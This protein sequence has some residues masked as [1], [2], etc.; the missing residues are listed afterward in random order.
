V[1][2]S[3]EIG[4]RIAEAQREALAP[5]CDCTAELKRAEA[6]VRE[7]ERREATAR[8][9]LT[10]MPDPA[11]A[12]EPSTAAPVPKPSDDA[13]R[14][15]DRL[16]FGFAR[17]SVL[18]WA[19]DERHIG[20]VSTRLAEALLSKTSPAPK[21]GTG[22]VVR[23]AVAHVPIAGLIARDAADWRACGLAATGP[24]VIDTLSEA[25][26][27]PAVKAILLD[28]NSPGGVAT[29][30]SDIAGAVAAA[31]KRKLV[32]AHIDE[33]GASAGYWIASQAREVSATRSTLV[34]SIGIYRV[35][36]DFARAF[37]AAG[38]T[39]HVVR[40]HELKG[41]GVEGAPITAPQLATEQA[42]IDRAFGM[43]KAD[44]A[45]ARGRDLSEHATGQLWFAEDA[46]ARGLI[47]HISSS[48][49]AHARAMKGAT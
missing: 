15:L 42:L 35:L 11:N 37:D 25:A 48:A 27:D 12:L 9:A 24:E 33:L 41:I 7:C 28:V 2:S 30:A 8:A 34:G 10:S 43:F 20:H 44:I 39:T 38:I 22:Y 13:S 6:F 17:M 47:D 29:F 26:R 23:D 16:C 32:H 5:S 14:L 18:L 45:R 31:G 3:V 40:S 4:R 49:D 36:Y 21:A 1:S 19:L 46:R